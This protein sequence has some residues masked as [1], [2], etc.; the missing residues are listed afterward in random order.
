MRGGSW[1]FRPPRGADVAD[2]PL[3]G[4]RRPARARRPGLLTR[5]ALSPRLHALAERIPGLRGH[6][7]AEGRALFEIV[8]GFVRSQALLAVVELDLLPMLSEGAAP[9]AQLAA[10]CGVPPDRLVVLLQ[11]AAA[12]K[13]VRLR[14]GLWHLAPRG[15]AFLAVPGLEAMVRHHPVLYRD[16]GDPVAFLRGETVPELAGFWPYVFGPLAETDADLARRYSGLMADSQALV[17]EDTLKLADLSGVTRL[18]DIGG[19]TGTFLR[20]VAARHPALELVLFDLPHVVAAA[21][22]FSPRLTVQPGDF[23]R[24]PIPRGADAVSLVRVLYDHPDTV[25]AALLSAVHEA[26]PPGGRILISEPMSGGARPDA[27]TD[28]YFAFYTLAMCSGRTRSAAEIAQ[29]LEKAGFS[30]VTRGRS[31]RP[32][33]TTLV[34]ARRS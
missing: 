15:A 6:A 30:E 22:R 5:L 10:R 3:P 14:R 31:R 25:V 7:R 18:M 2:L 21:P 34:Q 23:R 17:A 24:D 13:L 8:S 27:A 4:A 20:A 16:L 1:T 11:A 29:M 32:F 9:T 28:V 19:G 26:L 12:L 33:I